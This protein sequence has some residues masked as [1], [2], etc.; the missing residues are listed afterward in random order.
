MIEIKRHGVCEKGTFGEGTKIKE[1]F[2]IAVKNNRKFNKGI[3]TFKK[4]KVANGEKF[5]IYKDEILVRELY[6]LADK[7]GWEY[8]YVD[9]KETK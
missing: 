6:C 4:I 9:Y 1:H 7:F 8:G 3:C 5:E 2:K